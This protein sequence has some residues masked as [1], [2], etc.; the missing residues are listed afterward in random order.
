MTLMRMDRAELGRALRE[1]VQQTARRVDD[2][3]MPA[4][5]EAEAYVPG[6]DPAGIADD[7]IEHLSEHGFAVTREP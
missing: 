7:F 6:F 5:E 2:D 4:D 1:W 3:Y